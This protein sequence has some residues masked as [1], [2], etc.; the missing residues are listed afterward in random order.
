VILIIL[1]SL[2]LSDLRFSPM[3]DDAMPASR[4][5][6]S[7]GLQ[8]PDLAVTDK[9]GKIANAIGRFDISKHRESA[10]GG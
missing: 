9:V 8:F 3:D 5:S 7:K 2:I 10:R 1:V 4:V 6:S